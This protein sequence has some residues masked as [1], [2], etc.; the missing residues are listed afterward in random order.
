MKSFKIGEKNICNSQPCYVIAEFGLNHNGKE[1]LAVQMVEEAVRAGADAIKLSK[2]D[3]HHLV[4]ENR[5]GVLDINN[6]YGQ[7]FDIIEII[8]SMEFP[9]EVIEKIAQ[10][11]K[12]L[13]ID[14]LSAP[15]NEEN[16]DFLV[17]IGIPAIKIASGEL[18]NDP[19]LKYI[20]RKK[21][22]VILSTGMSTLSE[23]KHAVTVLTENGCTDLA[24]LHCI[25][26]YPVKKEEL[27]LRAIH[28]LTNEFRIPIGFSDHTLGIEA[29]PIAV[30]SG[31]C[32]I[33]K[34][35]TLNKELPGLDHRFSLDPYEMTRMI[36]D[37]RQIE[38]MLG[39]EK[40]LPTKA[41]LE[42]RKFGRRS[43]VAKTAIE[44]NTVITEEMLTM[45]RPGTGISPRDFYKVL[46]KTA[47]VKIEAEEVLTWDKLFK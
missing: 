33:E 24:L 45:K 19:F 40:K 26:T 21:I 4:M 6:T 38:L 37:I 39:V 1:G 36:K 20:A 12:K 13:K 29:A 9:Y 2:F 44:P 22:P 46:G 41:E 7:D 8:K 15:S 32:I 23:V 30:A 43:I 5:E 27:N 42:F 34:H 18:T 14:F 25:S 3:T 28:V 31:A 10:V 11:C 47:R 17:K 16:V 35:F